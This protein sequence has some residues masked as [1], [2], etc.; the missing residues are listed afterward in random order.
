MAKGPKTT[1]G[2]KTAKP[3]GVKM[4]TVNKPVAGKLGA[5]SFAKPARG[6]RSRNY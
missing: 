1:F 3:K 2:P 6:A 5:P 4:T